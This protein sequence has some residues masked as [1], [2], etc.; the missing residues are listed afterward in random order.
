[1]AE[2]KKLVAAQGKE[3]PKAKYFSLLEPP[4]RAARAADRIMRDVPN[5]REAAE[6]K[7]DVPNLDRAMEIHVKPHMKFIRKY[8]YLNDVD[9]KLLMSLM[10]VEQRG[11]DKLGKYATS[12]DKAEGIMQIMPLTKKE[13]NVDTSSV[14]DS[15]RGA[16]EYMRDMQKKFGKDFAVLGTVYHSGET[17]A[18][19]LDQQTQDPGPKTRNYAG[20]MDILNDKLRAGEMVIEH[21]DNTNPTESLRNMIPAA[22]APK[23][24]PKTFEE[25]V[26]RLRE[27]ELK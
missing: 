6:V 24:K 1:M 11:N 14:E 13:Y 17:N 15:I 26:T 10:A 16:A 3:P 2:G 12:E 9:P 5:Y 20:M 18:R 8:A 23:G 21:L 22:P 27:K 19:M 7:A 25:A 4:E